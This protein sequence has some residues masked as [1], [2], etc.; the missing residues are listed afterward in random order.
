MPWS[1]LRSAGN[2][3]GAAS[4]AWQG[5]MADSSLPSVRS[6]A[7]FALGGAQVLLSSGTEAVREAP[8]TCP[9]P[10]LSCQNTTVVTDLC[11]F[12]APGGQLLLTQFWDT[13]PVTGPVDSW[14][15]HGLW[16][17]PL[18]P[19][20]PV[21]LALTVWQARPL[22]WHLRRQLRPESRSRKHHADP[23]V[24]RQG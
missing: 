24:L 7:K 10:Q 15:L 20:N 23:A 14:T 4:S 6:I 18:L 16:Y 22:R 1:A 2:A 5:D 3:L 8:A 12:N 19:S 9:N 21:N 11:C 13:H 17:T